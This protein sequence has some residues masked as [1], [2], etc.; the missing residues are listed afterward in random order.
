MKV[1]HS[2]WSGRIRHWIR[3]L[4]DD[5]YEPLGEFRW[6]GH[7]TMEHISPEQALGLTFEQVQPGFTW[8]NTYE[9]C[10]FR[11]R[12]ELPGRAEGKRIVMNLKPGG[13]STLFVNGRSFGTYRADWVSEPHHYMEDNTLTRS[14]KAGESYEVLMETYAGHYYPECPD[15][16]CAT[17]P[18]LPG[19]F[20][21]PLTEGARRTLGV[22]T[23]GIWDE[24]A[25]QLYMD[26][27]TLGKLLE[28]LDETSLR[29]AKIAKALEQFTLRFAQLEGIFVEKVYT[30]KT[31]YGVCDLAKQGYF[32]AG[33]C[34]LHSGGL[35]ALFSQYPEE[36]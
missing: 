6:E 31:L 21:D 9:Y 10:W 26:V 36:R 25:Y 33:A 14:G 22:C 1:M 27:D 3:T 5:F 28:T 24:D 34:Y 23:Y 30:G 2:E 19:S 18:V 4:K 16:G 8:G 13:E 12:I 32:P 17:G 7:R 20:T 29:A 15:G 11:S 35:G